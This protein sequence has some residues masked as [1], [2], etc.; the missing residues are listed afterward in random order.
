MLKY[1]VFFLCMLDP[2]AYIRMDTFP[3]DLIMSNLTLKKTEKCMKEE[4]CL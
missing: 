1:D 4:N 3:F 2:R